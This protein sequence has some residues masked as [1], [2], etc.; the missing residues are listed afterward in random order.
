MGHGGGLL[1]L[2]HNGRVKSKGQ[3]LPTADGQV[4]RMEALQ[5]TSNWPTLEW[6]GEETGEEIGEATRRPI[7][8]EN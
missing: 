3:Q 7:N 6:R 2:Q 4:L 5:G 1:S 8:L